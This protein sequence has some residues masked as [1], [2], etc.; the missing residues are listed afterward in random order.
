MLARKPAG[1]H[2]APG[3]HGTTARGRRARTGFLGALA[4][5]S[6]VGCVH[7]DQTNGDEH[8]SATGLFTNLTASS[9]CT[10]SDP[11]T[12]IVSQTHHTLTSNGD[13]ATLHEAGGIMGGLLA[14]AAKLIPIPGVPAGVRGNGQNQNAVPSPQG[15]P[16]TTGCSGEK[17]TLTPAG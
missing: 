14:F 10:Q 12:G 4:A 15:S 11:A 5:I 9:D 16:A 2:L 6:L 7:I 1:R 13:T 8:M 17:T 3:R